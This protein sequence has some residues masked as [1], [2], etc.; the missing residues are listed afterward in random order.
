MNPHWARYLPA[1]ARR[2]LEEREHL[3]GIIGNTGWLFLDKIVRMGV[4]LVVNVWV[5][6]YLGPAQFGLFNYAVA[7]VALF[8]ALATLG[9][10]GIVVREIVKEPARRDEILGSV[11]AMKLAGGV[12]TLLMAVAAVSFLRH[13]DASTR[14]L[15]GIVAA[16]T[17]FQAFDVIDFWFQSQ[18]R[19]KYTVYARNTAFLII[20]GVKVFLIL[21]A[22]PLTAFALAALAETA[23]GAVGLVLAYRRSGLRLTA[24]RRSQ[25][26]CRELLRDSWPL[27]LGSISVML[28]M[29][30]DQIMLGDMLGNAEVGIY[31]AATKIS[32]VWYFIPSAIISSVLPA[33]I[34]TKNV[35]KDFYH[36]RLQRLFSL[37]AIMALLIA[38]PMTFLAPR[39]IFILYGDKFLPSV[40]VLQIHIWATLFV[41]LAGAQSVWD[42]TENMTRLALLRTLTGAVV[43][44]VLNLFFISKYGAKGAAMATL[45]SQFTAVYLFD[46]FTE[47]TRHLFIIKTKAILLLGAKWR[48]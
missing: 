34:Q 36:R 45:A 37:M 30:I 41:F 12:A 40:G 11:F 32:E 23:L 25:G 29:K 26:R 39:I 17:I 2:W 4:G 35:H 19:S 13:G 15:V 20:A 3:H 5:A 10:D 1:V 6:R 47:R 8:S 14:L 18:V 16:G 7:F 48:V 24:W 22:A 33:I 43:N 42:L 21:A 28:Y 27:I 31:T 46:L 44:I 38:V 9:L